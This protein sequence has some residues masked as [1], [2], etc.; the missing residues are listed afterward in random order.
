VAYKKKYVPLGYRYAPKDLTCQKCG[1]KF[2]EPPSRVKIGRGQ[3]CSRECR[4]TQFETTCDACGKVLVVIPSRIAHGQGGKFCNRKCYEIGERT[5]VEVTCHK[6]GCDNEYFITPSDKK[7]HNYQFC[8]QECRPRERVKDTDIELIVRDFLDVFGMDYETQKAVPTGKRR[9]RPYTLDVYI[10]SL[11]LAIEADGPRHD[12]RQK[13]DSIRDAIVKV[14]GIETLRL[15]HIVIKRMAY[16]LDCGPSYILKSLQVMAKNDD[17]ISR[18]LA[19]L[20]D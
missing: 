12:K 13:E 9:G 3:F 8:S 15:S 10:P 2:H 17:S 19:V 14:H 4:K 1:T 16:L 20:R 6:E 7:R 18:F 11:D 5:R